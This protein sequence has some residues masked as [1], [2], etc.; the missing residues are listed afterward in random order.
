MTTRKKLGKGTFGRW[1]LHYLAKFLEMTKYL[2][3]VIVCVLAYRFVFVIYLPGEYDKAFLLLVLLQ[4]PLSQSL[5]N[6]LRSLILKL[7][8]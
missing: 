5:G 3:Y 8:Q 2:Q 1:L 6:K 7:L 4:Y